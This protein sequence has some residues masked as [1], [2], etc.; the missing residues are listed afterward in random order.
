MEHLEQPTDSQRGRAAFNM[1]ALYLAGYTYDQ[2]EL[3]HPA[4]M[5]EDRLHDLLIK[6][7]KR[8]LWEWTVKQHLKVEPTNKA[9][10]ISKG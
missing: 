9:E 5:T 7:L 1:V 3:F 10:V 2:I 4:D 6:K 8:L